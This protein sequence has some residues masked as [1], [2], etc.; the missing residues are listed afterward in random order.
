VAIGGTDEG[1][2]TA[3]VVRPAHAHKIKKFRICELLCKPRIG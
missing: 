2:D 1:C 3:V